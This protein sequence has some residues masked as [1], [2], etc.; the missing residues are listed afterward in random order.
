MQWPS[1][2]S[3][4]DSLVLQ[5]FSSYMPLPSDADILPGHS[6]DTQAISVLSGLE[7]AEYAYGA[8]LANRVRLAHIT[9]VLSA[10]GSLMYDLLVP[11]PELTATGVSYSQ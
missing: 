11:R 10:F 4:A 7:D 8:E 9:H 2:C 6:E 5:S 1:D 3:G